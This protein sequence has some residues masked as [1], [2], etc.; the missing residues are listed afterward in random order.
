MCLESPSVDCGPYV[1]GETACLV[2]CETDLDCLPF[3]L[4]YCLYDECH[5]KK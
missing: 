1:C 2:E 4:Y 3:S 5:P